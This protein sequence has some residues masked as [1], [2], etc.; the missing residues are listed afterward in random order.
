M[1]DDPQ[2]AVGAVL[3]V[4]PGP[5]IIAVVTGDHAAPFQRKS[6]VEEPSPPPRTPAQASV[7]EAAKTTARSA[8]VPLVMACQAVPFQRRIAPPL[9]TAKMSCAESP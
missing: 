7:A 3:N 1:G 6:G 2:I 5:K 4:D 8:V 9:P